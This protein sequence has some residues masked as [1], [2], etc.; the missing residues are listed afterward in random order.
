MPT[1]PFFQAAPHPAASRFPASADQAVFFGNTPVV[2]LD[3][4]FN[5]SMIALIEALM[6]LTAEVSGQVEDGQYRFEFALPDQS[7]VTLQGHIE[8]GR[9]IYCVT[10]SPDNKNF[11]VDSEMVIKDRDPILGYQMFDL[12]QAAID[13]N[14][15]ERSFQAEQ[16]GM[17]DADKQE[18]SAQIAE[19]RQD[20]DDRKEP[21]LQHLAECKQQLGL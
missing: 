19:V 3:R 11:T 2:S 5:E 4:D 13:H 1:N 21:I 20:L 14:R 10:H 16:G 9:W 12:V 15:L 8:T 18:Y 7:S 17:S 6:N